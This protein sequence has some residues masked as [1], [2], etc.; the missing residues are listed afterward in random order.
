MAEVQPRPSATRGRGSGRGGRGGYSSRG[1]RRS[2]TQEAANG[3]APAALPMVSLDEQGEM[4]QLKMK[5]TSELSFLRDMFPDWS[6]DDL[7]LALQDSDGDMPRT[8]EK[9][10][11]GELSMPMVA[12]TS[13][14]CKLLTL[15]TQATYLNSLL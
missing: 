1:G 4:G 13:H 8:C 5:Y 11:E 12:P 6:D 9:I 10:T 14:A 7:V 15:F 3:D 2:S